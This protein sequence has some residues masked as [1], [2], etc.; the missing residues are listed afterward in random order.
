[1]SEESHRDERVTSD[2]SKGIFGSGK[3]KTEDKGDFYKTDS[4]DGD[5]E[6]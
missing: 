2:L 3:R 4:E 1:M 6:F 5:R